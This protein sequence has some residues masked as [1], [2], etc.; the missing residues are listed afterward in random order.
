MSTVNIIAAM[1]SSILAA[2]G[3]SSAPKIATAQAEPAANADSASI[4]SGGAAYANYL[5]MIEQQESG[6]TM[7]Q[8]A[9]EDPNNP[10]WAQAVDAAVKENM[11]G[12]SIGGAISLAGTTPNDPIKYT[13]GDPVTAASQAYYEKQAAIYMSQLGELVST[14][15]AKGT[16]PGQIFAAI[17]DLQA[18]QPDAFR[19]IM[20]WTPAAEP[21]SIE[22][23]S[24]PTG[25]PEQYLNAGGQVV[26]SA[27]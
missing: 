24:N 8:M 22:K 2:T 6:R 19:A 14:E 7:R 10:Q 4:S 1:Q 20:M 18:K 5:R 15:K 9:L 25:A 26:N 12:G 21:F 16:A 17:C 23:A 11:L 13:C 3:K 27:A